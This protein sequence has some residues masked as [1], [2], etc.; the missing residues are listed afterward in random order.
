MTKK[1]GKRGMRMEP[2][3]EFI[4]T[5]VIATSGYISRSDTTNKKRL[6][7]ATI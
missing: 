7:L 1:K 2:R 4:E 5:N 3:P 6:E